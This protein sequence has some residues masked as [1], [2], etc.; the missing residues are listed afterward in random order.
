MSGTHS[1][2][3]QKAVV[4]MTTFNRIDCARINQE[5]IK[6]NYTN[7]FPIVHACSSS[8]YEKYLEDVLAPCE[9]PSLPQSQASAIATLQHGALNLLKQSLAA[10]MEKFSP[11]YL[12]HIEGDTWIMDEQVI[13][14]IIA[15]MD[16][17]K[18]L[19]ICTSAWDEDLLAFKYLKQP[20]LTTRLQL[21]F[22]G[23]VRKLGYPYRLTYRDSL[24]TQFFVIRATPEML[25]CFQ[26]L[27]PIPG[28]DLEQA[29]YRAFM[30]RFGEQNILRQRVREPIHPFNRFV[31]EKL[32]LYSQHWPARGTANDTR[33]PTHP[34]YISPTF[35][36]KRETLLKFTSMRRGEY[37]QKL[38]N[39][40][41]FEY[42]NLGASRT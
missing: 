3:N 23:V 2:K 6:L 10:A 39:A 37:I 30:E 18:K 16:H 7:P 21:W 9:Q 27:E 17:N 29:L 32:S 20:R 14:N 12:V 1:K 40:Q 13:H 5:I 11:E 26:T 28:L 22:A 4:C 33:D 34:R 15:K 25:E 19:M 42:Y 35:D 24:A 8:Y 36:G 38:L 31:C 41:T